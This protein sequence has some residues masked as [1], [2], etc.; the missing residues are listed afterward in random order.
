M[1]DINKLQEIIN[2]NVTNSQRYIEDGFNLYNSKNT[3]KLLDSLQYSPTDMGE[4]RTLDDL[5]K[6]SKEEG[7]KFSN[8]N[9]RLWLLKYVFFNINIISTDELKD[10]VSATGFAENIMDTKTNV[11]EFDDEWW[12]ERGRFEWRDICFRSSLFLNILEQFIVL[13]ISK[14]SIDIIYDYLDKLENN[15][16]E[17]NSPVA[18]GLKKD[19]QVRLNRLVKNKDKIDLIFNF[20]LQVELSVIS[21]DLKQFKIGFYD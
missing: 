3:K 15:L 4:E 2:D 7:W 5:K 11:S 17:I 21:S 20:L 16:S 6:Y 9:A 8:W 12:I 18:K 1:K 10:A 14:Y 19:Y 13:D